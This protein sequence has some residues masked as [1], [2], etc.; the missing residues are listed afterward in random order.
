MTSSATL[1]PHGMWKSP[2]SPAYVAGGIRLSDVQWDSDGQTLVWLET[3]SGQGVLVCASAV[4]S[5][6]PCDLTIDL[7]VRAH[8]GYGGGEFTVSNGR[9]FFVEKSGRLYRQSL[10]GGQPQAIT[11]EF[12]H[13][14]A[15]TVSPDGIW[16]IFV[17]SYEHTDVLAIVDSEGRQ[18]PQRL[19]SGHDF[20]MQPRW[21]PDG[22]RIA[23]IAW[24]HPQMPWDG[25]L[26]YLAKLREG[27]AIPVVSESMMVA[28]GTNVVIFQPEFS[29]DGRWL[30][31]IS[32]ESG[33]GNLYLYDLEQGHSQ[34]LMLAEA[35]SGA[36]AWVQGLRTYGWSHDSAHIYVIRNEQGIARLYRHTL[37]SATS[38]AVAG[39][40]DYTWLSQPAIAPTAD[41]L[42]VV[43]SANVRPTRLVM[44][45]LGDEEAR[46]REGEEV[47]G[48]GAEVAGEESVEEREPGRETPRRGGAEMAVKQEARVLCRSQAE[49][50]TPEEMSEARPVTWTSAGGVM[51]H[52]LLYL[53]PGT[54]PDTLASAGGLLPPA[55]LRIHGGPTAQVVASFS[56]D[57]QFF[58]TRGYVVLSVNYRGSTG[59][60]RAYMEA[61]RGDWGVCDMEDVISGAT[62]LAQQGL[63][64]AQR[65]VMMGGS[66]GG[67]TLL[68]A[69]CH[70][71]GL[72]CAAICLFGISNLFTL[73]ADT[74]K[75]E[76]HYLDSLVG[77]LPEASAIY[78]ERSPLFHA[79]QIR[80][81]IAIFQGDKDISVPRSQSDAIVAALKRSGVPHEY[82]VY[83]GEGH[84][85]RKSET[86]ERFYQ[87][88]DDFLR[89]YVLFT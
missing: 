61:M 77:P 52:G 71:P 74:H 73:V 40:E 7:S 45:T 22:R 21:H 53:P 10:Q 87:A 43:A 50:I 49:V 38:E 35:E 62:Y 25:T 24:N 82:H 6:A 51:V 29:P 57:V 18:W 3:R 59:Y 37:A 80:D 9:V 15:P 55:I 4:T 63:A 42:A 47:Q 78:R 76:E 36:P 65:L 33:W 88:V 20:Y 39:L 12:G 54:T 28:G 11:P 13:A 67:Y 68:R 75:F 8:L 27:D 48:E 58:T 83:E 79:E 70:A 16:V 5:D 86:I 32:D 84:G 89:Q 30:S 56:S 31:Y 17:H 19:V 14:A 2:I 46:E 41:I 85:W 23:Y 26:L 44:L 64:D 34:A 1:Q 72:F 81:P 66:A 69:L 60:G